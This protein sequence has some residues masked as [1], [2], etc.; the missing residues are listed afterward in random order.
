MPHYDIC[1]L[2]AAGVL[3]G[4]FSMPCAGDTQA[5]VLAHAMRLAGTRRIEVWQ[6]ATLVYERPQTGPVAAL[7]TAHTAR[8]HAAE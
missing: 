1:Y 6:G 7:E 4:T 2:D 3:L 8:L 5:R